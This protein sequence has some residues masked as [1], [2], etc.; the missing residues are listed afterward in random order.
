MLEHEQLSLNEEEPWWALLGHPLTRAD[1]IFEP[2]GHRAA[3]DLQFRH[4]D[5]NP[6]CVTLTLRQDVVEVVVERQASTLH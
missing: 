3:L 6:R 5:D 2:D 1:E 4:D